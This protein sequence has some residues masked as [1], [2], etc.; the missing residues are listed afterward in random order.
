MYTLR[1]VYPNGEQK[2]QLIGDVYFLTERT[3]YEAFSAAFKTC[4]GVDHVADLDPN[5]TALSKTTQA[6]INFPVDLI[7][8]FDTGEKYYIMSPN[9]ETF[10]NVTPP[11]K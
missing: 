2:N 9:G 6:F 11:K 8:L 3:S 7:P 5:S 10:A 4:F 1:T